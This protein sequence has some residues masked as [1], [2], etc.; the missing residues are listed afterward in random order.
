MLVFIVAFLSISTVLFA[1]TT[2]D[3]VMALKKLEA[4]CQS[5]I[6]YRDYSGAL[7]DAK[8]PV[9]VFLES[10]E[11][12]KNTNL[13][14]SIS[15]AIRHYEFAGKIWHIRI[16]ADRSS[17]EHDE[18]MLSHAGFINI[19][20]TL[21]LEITEIY[22]QAKHQAGSEDYYSIDL[23][24]PLIWHEGS[25]EL[26]NT[27]KLYTGTEEDT[28]NNIDE[29]K[30]EIAKLKAENESFKKQLNTVGKKKR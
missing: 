1:D 27:S 30:K 22:P 14:D 3:A 25:K 19:N 28:A 12:R 4:R 21:G 6:S 5:G 24:L 13:T 7:A 8:F 26:A 2:K 18:Y 17:L 20:S 10:K 11:S 15:T 16:S 29:L 9:N 23:L